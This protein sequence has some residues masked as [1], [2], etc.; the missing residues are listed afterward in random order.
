MN[1]SGSYQILFKIIKNVEI[2]VGALGLCKFEK[3]YYFYTG[4]AKK[5]L[6]QRIRR[7]IK[8]E[9]KLHWH[10]DYIS[11][12]KEVEILKIYIFPSDIYKECEKNNEILNLVGSL[13]PYPRFGSS[14]CNNCPS[15]LIRFKFKKNFNEYLKKVKNYLFYP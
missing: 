2:T 9:K 15:H 3:G 10:I 13:I 1:N 12:L 6:I 14:D 8:K 4:S 7:H 11:G 5:N